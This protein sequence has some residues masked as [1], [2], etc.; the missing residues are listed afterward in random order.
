MFQ[1][2]IDAIDHVVR[3]NY[4]RSLTPDDRVCTFQIDRYILVRSFSFDI[5]RLVP[6]ATYFRQFSVGRR[7][8]LSGVILKYIDIDGNSSSVSDRQTGHLSLPRKRY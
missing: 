8:V 2:E 7:E 3:V 1:K 6:V 4:P 5:I